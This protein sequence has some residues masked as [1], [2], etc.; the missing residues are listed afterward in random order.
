M[1]RPMA[2][3]IAALSNNPESTAKCEDIDKH[4]ANDDDDDT[5]TLRRNKVL[6]ARDAQ[7]R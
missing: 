1:T 2:S 4:N 7:K 5:P 6:I 3:I